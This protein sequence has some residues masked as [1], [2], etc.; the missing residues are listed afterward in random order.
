MKTKA[1]SQGNKEISYTKAQMEALSKPIWINNWT[2]FPAK[3][4]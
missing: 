2:R 1:L 4:E 3:G